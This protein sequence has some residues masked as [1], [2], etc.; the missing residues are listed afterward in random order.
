MAVIFATR[1]HLALLGE[2][3]AFGLLG[4]FVFS[5][6]S[7]DVIR[8]KLGRRDPAFWIGVLTTAMLM[9]AWGVNLLE[10]ELA[11]YFGGA[12]TAVGMLIAVGVRRGWFMNMLMQLPSVQRLQAR[13]YRASEELVEDELKGLMTLTEAVE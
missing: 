2:M 3:Y 11:T 7:L 5:S 1:G 4:A 6:M 8:W 10:K 13:A 9:L 12:V